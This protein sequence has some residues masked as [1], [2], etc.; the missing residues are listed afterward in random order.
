MDTWKSRIDQEY[1]R[2]QSQISRREPHEDINWFLLAIRK[3]GEERA[4]EWSLQTA[5]ARLKVSRGALYHYLKRGLETAPLVKVMR[6]AELSEIDI[7]R[8]CEWSTPY[9]ERRALKARK[10]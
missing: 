10:T 7:A 3:A 5:A 2:W 1:G 6:L 4:E 8:L 9:S